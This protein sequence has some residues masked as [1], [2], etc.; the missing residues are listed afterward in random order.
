MFFPMVTSILIFYR[1]THIHAVT[2]QLTNDGL[3]HPR[4]PLSLYFAQHLAT[5]RATKKCSLSQGHLPSQETSL[6]HSTLEAV[7]ASVPVVITKRHSLLLR[8][9]VTFTCGAHLAMLLLP[10]HQAVRHAIHW[11]VLVSCQWHVT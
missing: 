5:L 11:N 10:A 8:I 2:K 9:N 1:L 4:V 7:P 3:V 6:T